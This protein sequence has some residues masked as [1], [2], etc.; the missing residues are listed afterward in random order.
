MI[1]F[2]GVKSLTIP[3]GGV[4]KITRK[5]DGVVLWEAPKSYTN[6]FVPSQA[7]LNGRVNSS[8]TVSTCDG[9]IISNWI[10]VADHTPF[11]ETTKIYIK[12]ANFSNY[13]NGSTKYAKILGYRYKPSSN[14][15]G[16]QAEYSGSNISVKNE[17]NGVISTSGSKLASL[18]HSNIN[19]IVLILNV[20]N[21]ALT[22]SDIENIVIT[23]DEPIG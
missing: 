5:S 6:L 15:T 7:V 13:N 20:K 22:L 11:A 18:M 8:A 10:Y 16:I 21:T 4:K 2:T 1:D 23:I 17:G 14:Y 19:Y 3:E 9:H 12:G